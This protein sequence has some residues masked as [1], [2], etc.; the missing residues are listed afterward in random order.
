MYADLY[1]RTVNIRRYA[2]YF[3]FAFIPLSYIALIVVSFMECR[4][5]NQTW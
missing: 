5:L 4:P 2:L 3:A 1:Q